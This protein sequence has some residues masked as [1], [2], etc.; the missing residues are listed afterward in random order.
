MP[1]GLLITLYLAS[2]LTAGLIAGVVAPAKG[3][4]QGYWVIVA[5]LFPP[6]VI[7]LLL[8]PRGRGTYRRDDPYFDRDDIDS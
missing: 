6:S 8:L 5:F 2:A 1:T 7:L 3:R 4:H